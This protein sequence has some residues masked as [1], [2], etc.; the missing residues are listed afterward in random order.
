VAADLSQLLFLFTEKS[1]ATRTLCLSL[2]VSCSLF[3]D[4]SSVMSMA[5]RFMSAELEI[6]WNKWSWSNRSTAPTFS[7][8]TEQQ[9]YAKQQDSWFPG[10]DSNIA[11]SEYKSKKA[12]ITHTHTHTHTCSIT[13]LT[14]VF[15]VFRITT[16]SMEHS[17]WKDDNSC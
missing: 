5:E 13:S 16:N 3:Y 14:L 4:P 7:G 8:G 10:R 12:T 17:T 11:P 2:S 15:I 1:Q 6:I 9:N